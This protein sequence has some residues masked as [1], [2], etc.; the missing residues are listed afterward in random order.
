MIHRRLLCAAPA[1]LVLAA[2][3]TGRVAGGE[4]CSQTIAAAPDAAPAVQAALDEAKAAD[5]VCLEPGTF[6]FTSALTLASPGTTLLGLG[7]VVLDFSAAAP[8][9]TGLELAADDVTVEGVTVQDP[10][11]DGVRAAGISHPTLRYVEVVWT[12]GAPGAAGDGIRIEDATSVL[13]DGCAV[14]GAPGAGIRLVG[15]ETGVVRDGEVQGSAP[16]ILVA[17][18]RRIDVG[19]NDVHDNA[20]GVALLARPGDALAA[21]GVRIY[22]NRLIHNDGV[23]P[24]ASGPGAVPP[25]IALWLV[26]ADGNEIFGNAVKE[27]GSAGLA[28]VGWAAA[29]GAAADAPYD[30]VPEGNWLHD[31]VFYGN[32]GDPSEAAQAVSGTDTLADLVW[33]GVVDEA[34]DDPDGALSNCFSGNGEATFLDFAYGRPASAQSR[35]PA[36]VAC[37]HPALPPVDL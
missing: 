31:N 10:G 17:G 7:D 23:V 33:D 12:E 6:S 22:R 36:A 1:L 13:V 4:G 15:C 19:D 21:G 16:G 30:P 8:G 9:T 26:A 27:N 25:G 24:G 32:A 35:D 11:G 20:G 2:C 34:K 18:S 3:G 37:E 5:V 14:A 28:V 29:G